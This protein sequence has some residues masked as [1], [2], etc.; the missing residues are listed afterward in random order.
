[1]KKLRSDKFKKTK[2]AGK[3]S[4]YGI[5][6]KLRGINITGRRKISVGFMQSVKIKLIIPIAVMSVIAVVSAC[7][8]NYGLKRVNLAGEEISS[9]YL[10]SVQLL[11]DIKEKT[12]KLQK[13][14][15]SYIVSEDETTMKRIVEDILDTRIEMKDTIEQTSKLLDSKEQKTRFEQFQGNLSEFIDTLDKVKGYCAGNQVERARE[16]VNGDMTVQGQALI[17]ELDVMTDGNSTDAQKSIKNMKSI[18]SGSRVTGYLFM[19]LSFLMFIIACIVVIKG[20]TKPLEK[21]VEKLMEINDGIKE[22]RGDLTQRMP[23]V[24]TKDEIAN[25]AA[26]IDDFIETLQ[27]IIKKIT[28][29]SD[30]LENISDEVADNVG[31]SNTNACDV[32]AVMEQMSATME[33]LSATVSAV[34]SNTGCVNAEVKE[35][36]EKSSQMHEHSVDMKD[37][38]LKL[39]QSAI[40]NKDSTDE[41]IEN[42]MTELEKAIDDS[43]KVEKV[44]ELT[45]EILEISSQT[46]LLALNASIEAARAGEAGKGFAVVADEIRKLAD[47]TKVTA[48]KIQDIN[49][50]V[51]VAVH[52]LVDNSNTITGYM[53]DTILPDY[54]GF[55]DLGRQYREDADAVNEA[56]NRFARQAAAIEKLV[57]EIVESIQGVS[58]AVDE[59]ADGISNAASSTVELVFQLENIGHQMDSNKEIVDLLKSESDRFSLV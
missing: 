28:D 46:N 3:N 15:Y 18:Y 26:G 39:E 25:M 33:E 48:G 47:S 14:G 12:Q 5:A 58:K 13:L 21:L 50:Q 52:N 43:K 17:D 1:M 44:N 57:A 8:S 11:G 27:K 38:A 24:K 20:I 35:I 51:I 22:G 10:A 29:S 9:K 45:D 31:S 7:V 34:N 2:K 55:V 53:R 40:V 49:E 59:S 6:G 41:M 30:K 23:E 32:S 19:T 4:K 56:M 42:I 37:R 54:D 16:L 36:S